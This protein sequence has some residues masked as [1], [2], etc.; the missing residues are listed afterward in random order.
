MYQ[1]STSAIQVHVIWY[2]F[3]YQLS[4]MVLLQKLQQDHRHQRAISIVISER[5]AI[6]VISERCLHD[7]P[8]LSLPLCVQ[9]ART[10]TAD[11]VV[12][13]SS[14]GLMRECSMGLM[15]ECSMGLMRECSMGLMR[16]CSMRHEGTFTR[17]VLQGYRIDL[18]PS[19]TPENVAS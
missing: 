18:L 3:V 5:S 7:P 4:Y 13:E 6:I 8:P 17:G 11:L 15:R 19:P 1:Q 14:M 10:R 2:A 9:T 12:R 16:E